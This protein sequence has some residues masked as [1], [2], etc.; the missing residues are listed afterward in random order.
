MGIIFPSLNN[1]V[2]AVD[3]SANHILQTVDWY[4]SSLQTNYLDVI[5]L[6]YPNSFMN[7][8]EVAQT[9]ASLKA[10]GKVRNFGVSNHYP[11][12]FETLQAALDKVNIKLV[13]NEVEISV[14]NPRYLNYNATTVDHA[15]TKGYRNLAWGGL[16]GDSTGGLNRLFTKVSE[17]SK[18]L[19]T[20]LECVGTQLG[21]TDP[22]VM[23]LAWSLSHP[24]GFIPL[25]GTT[26]VSRVQSLVNALNIAP[27]IS[28]VQWWKIGGDA[29]LCALADDQCNYDLY[30]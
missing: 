8:E 3:T 2:V 29:G 15:Y 10:S 20:S 7:A 27:K 12:H 14:W 19:I 11:S 1:T 17:R 21:V 22:A 16:A 24:S 4:L 26:K 25:I 28:T 9:F 18:K 5:L 6:H 13:T 23:A 30:K